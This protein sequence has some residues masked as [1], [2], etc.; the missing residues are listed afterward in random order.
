ML[1]AITREPEAMNALLADLGRML[2][3]DAAMQSQVERF[4]A[5]LR[6]SDDE[7]R[8]AQARRHAQRLILLLQAGLMRECAPVEAANAFIESRF[9]AEWGRVFGLMPRHEQQSRLIERAFPS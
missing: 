7:V 1:R 9:D 3:G 8:E 6:Q 2:Q 4:Q 5:A